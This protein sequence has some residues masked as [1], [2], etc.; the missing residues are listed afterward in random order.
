MS[1]IYLAT[2]FSHSDKKVQCE[3]AEIAGCITVTLIQQGLVVYSPIV[4]NYALYQ[5]MPTLGGDFTS[6]QRHCL[7][8]LSGASQLL[9][10]QIKG[11]DASHGVAAEIAYAKTLNIPVYYRKFNHVSK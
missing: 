2:P 9:I 11:W 10:A 1:Y 3:R 7:A 6:W 8:M 4:H 5:I